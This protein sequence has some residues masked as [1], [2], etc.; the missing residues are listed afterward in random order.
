MVDGSCAISLNTLQEWIVSRLDHGA[1]FAFSK[2]SKSRKSLTTRN[3][4]THLLGV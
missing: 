2:I 1:I 3:N 4:F